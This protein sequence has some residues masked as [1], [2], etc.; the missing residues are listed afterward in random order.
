MII[1]ELLHLPPCLCSASSPHAMGGGLFIRGLRSSSGCWDF[2]AKV[3]FLHLLRPLRACGPRTPCASAAA[4]FSC[5]PVPV[6]PKYKVLWRSAVPLQP[7]KIS[8]L[9]L[10]C[11]GCCSEDLAAIV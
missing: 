7:F 8:L 3:H 4:M 9:L 1:S 2:C 6:Q 11:A 5:H 10:P